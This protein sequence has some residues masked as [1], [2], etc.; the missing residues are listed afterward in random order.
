MLCGP[1]AGDESERKRTRTRKENV[2]GGKRNRMSDVRRED[3]GLSVLRQ[4]GA[5][6]VANRGD[7][8]AALRG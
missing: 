8:C 6:G 2:G 3:L 1:L 4:S 7:L 5:E